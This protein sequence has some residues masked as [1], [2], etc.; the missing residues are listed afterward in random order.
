MIK[1]QRDG[2]EMVCGLE[3]HIQLLT[4]SKLFCRDSAS[5]GG[6]ANDHTSAISLAHPGTLP[7]VNKKAIEFACKLG[8][9][10]NCTIAPVSFFDRK[11]YFYPDLPKG[12][13]ITQDKKSICKAGHLDLDID[14]VTERVFIHKIHL[15]EDAG[16]SIHDVDDV[17]SYIDLNRAGVPLLELVTEPCIHHP[18]VAA[19][20]ISALR[21]EAMFLGI[22]DGN[23]Q[24]GSIRCDANISIRPVGSDQLGT[25]T[26][27][28]NMNSL[29]YIK[30]AL[31][32]EFDRQLKL[33]KNGE[34]V[35]QETRGFNPTTGTTFSM[36]SK[37]MAFD[38]RYFPDPDLP[39]VIIQ[40]DY[41]EKIK[42]EMPNSPSEIR[43]KF[44]NNLKIKAEDAIIL[45]ESPHIAE[46]FNKISEI[47]SPLEA[48]NW[49]IHIVRPFLSENNRD[50]DELKIVPERLSKLIEMA[51]NG[52]IKLRES[53][54][55]LLQIVEEHPDSPLEEV[56]GANNFL[57]ESG[58]DEG[59]ELIINQVLKENPKEAERFINGAKNLQGWLIGEVLKQSAGSLD[60]KRVAT[61]IQKIIKK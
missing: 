10:T 11:N 51:K 7:M 29:R 19:A 48:A 3:I 54:N 59:I 31:E 37:E 57:L 27:I 42:R 38:Y 21:S 6:A 45:T 2:Y 28:K 58:G 56:L 24:E 55:L 12:Y 4:D 25:R 43:L 35:I 44:V 5:F 17:Y 23:L 15:E 20:F 34:S 9:A 30:K 33:I 8:L 13:Q 49:I 47:C 39:P 53:K 18:Q 32:Y 46:Y 16:K 36:R 60:P 1:F 26:E 50:F 14:G 52:Q 22:C 40:S 41:L 61:L